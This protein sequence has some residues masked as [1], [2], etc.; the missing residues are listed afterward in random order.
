MNKL[1]NLPAK[2]LHFAYLQ[3]HMQRGGV[4]VVFDQTT[5]FLESIGGKVT[6]LTPYINEQQWQKPTT[7]CIAVILPKLQMWDEENIRFLENYI[8]QERIDLIFYS[9]NALHITYQIATR[10]KTRLVPWLHNMLYSELIHK[11]YEGT[12]FPLM[13]L[14]KLKYILA[15]YSGLYWLRRT[16]IYHRDLGF[17][18][19]YLV[20]HSSYQKQL[21]K[22]FR[23]SDTDK[24]LPLI[25]TI[26]IAM[27]VDPYNKG[28]EIVYIGRLC[29]VQKQVTRLV[30]IWAK[31]EHLLPEWVL[32]I[33]GTGPDE[34]A[35]RRAIVKHS[36]K[37]VHLCGYLSEPERIYRSASILCLTSVYEGWPMVLVEAQNHGVIPIAFNCCS[38]IEAIIGANPAAGVLVPHLDHDAYANE[39]L[40]LCRDDKYREQLRDACLVKRWDYAPHVNDT[41]WKQLINDIQREK[42][43]R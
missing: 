43:A 29:P 27:D 7:Q 19:R 16:Q 23:L 20:L 5:K 22:Q 37:H 18:W 33:Y 11:K 41:V 31:I 25:N 15:Y 9:S 24:I 32:K 1:E 38:G 3:P 21:Q 13:S 28:K 30:H 14:N 17:C 39:L 2:G 10:L 6:Y 35:I 34:D 4:E 26:P 42:A 12:L 40:K 8:V 36:L